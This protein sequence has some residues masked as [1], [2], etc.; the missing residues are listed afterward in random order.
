MEKLWI[1]RRVNRVSQKLVSKNPPILFVVHPWVG[2]PHFRL[3]P[4]CAGAESPVARG[5]TQGAPVLAGYGANTINKWWMF[6]GHAT[7]TSH[8]EPKTCHVHWQNHLPKHENF[9]GPHVAAMF[10]AACGG[11]AS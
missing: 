10:S 6:Y 7:Q 5:S 11:S 9:Q 8:T 1:F 2:S 3:R 4:D